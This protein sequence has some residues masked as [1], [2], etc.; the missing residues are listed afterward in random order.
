[1][2]NPLCHFAIHA[3]D[4]NRAMAF[5]TA[6]FSWRFEPWGPPG[7]WRIFT[8]QPGVE[9]ALQ[10]RREPVTGTGMRGF[11]CSISVSDVAATTKQIV[12]HG[13]QILMPGFLIQG[14]GTVA[15][16]QDTEGNHVS[17]IQYLP[18]ALETLGG[19]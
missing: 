10:T 5:Y 1:M 7:F 18:S 12:K 15:K 14:V 11:E 3:E 6:V 9:G 16:F 19:S 4:C 17:V 8:G 13:G 2:P